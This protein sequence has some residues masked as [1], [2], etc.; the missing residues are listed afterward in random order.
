M[1]I[2]DSKTLDILNRIVDV[3]ELITKDKTSFA[4]ALAEL[5]AETNKNN[6]AMIDLADKEQQLLELQTKC[7]VMVKEADEKL[8]LAET[9][10]QEIAKGFSELSN[11][12]DL[13]ISRQK[14]LD[15]ETKVE[16]KAYKQAKQ[17]AEKEIEKLAALQQELNVRESK[18]ADM[19]S[20]ITDR[21]NKMKAL[22]GA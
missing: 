21:L 8:A 20:D 22:A 17:D 19:E 7:E 4:L 14:M 12:K 2:V 11:Q 9:N 16:T 6:Q 3:V 15:T 5:T 10:A 18:L 1:A 13:I